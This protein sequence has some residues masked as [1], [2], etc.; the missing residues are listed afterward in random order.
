MEGL[1]LQKFYRSLQND[2]SANQLGNEEGASQEQLFTELAVGLLSEGGE[3]E[4]VRIAYDEKVS[5]T[6][7]QHKIN[8]YSLSENLETLD[9]FISIYN[10]TDSIAGLNKAPVETAQKR[11][12]NFF[13]TA[14]YKDYAKEIEESS[15]IFD[16][17]NTLGTSQDVREG[18]AR[19]NAFILTDGVFN[20][21][22]V[23][24]Q[25]ISGYPIYFRVI[26][27][28]YL[29]N[30]S[31]KSHI[32]IEIDFAAD[33]F[34]IPFI[35]A[36]SEN[37]QYNSYLAIIPG[38]ALANIYER[39]GARL[40][41]QNIRSFLQFTGKINKGIRNTILKEPHMF[42]AF[43]N[44]I[45][46]TADTLEVSADG[47][48][49]SKVHDLQIVNGG[50][51]TASIFHTWKKDKADVSNIHVQLKL[52]VVKEKEKFSEI[53]SRI[54]E[55]ANT[56]N[57]VSVSDLSS[58]QPFHIEIEKL[59]RT[60]W[61]APVEGRSQQTSWFYERARGQYKNARAKDGFTKVKQGAFDLKNPKNQLFTKEDLAKYCNAF[62]EQTDGKKII[63]GPHIV[64]R[65]NQKNYAHFVGLGFP[66]KL[67]NI[68]FEDVVSK[69]I[70]YKTAEKKYGV[71]PNAIGDMR[72]V[73]VPYTL[74][75]FN[76]LT[77][78]K[79]DLFKIWRAQSISNDLKDCLYNLMIEVEQFIK[80]N[81]TGSL[82]GEF[83]KKEECWNLLKN[84]GIKI[85]SASIKYDLG[86]GKLDPF[87]T[88]VSQ[89]E[90]ARIQNEQDLQY[91]VSISPELWKHI[92]NWGR[93]TDNLT[94]RQQDFAFNLS[95][96]VRNGGKGISESEKEGG[97]KILDFVVDKFPEVFE[98]F[99]EPES[100]KAKSTVPEITLQIIQAVVTWDR[101]AKRFKD[102]EYR[103][104]ADLASGNQPLVD[105]NLQKANWYY[106][107][108]KQYG[109]VN[110]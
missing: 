36:P 77:G 10:G 39:Y 12:I 26:D 7:I 62:S 34:K 63:T 53:V 90:T 67:D 83:A 103:F 51:T 87:R 86:N 66:K 6:G 15:E 65:G 96:R 30:I 81:A 4:N 8:A 56:Q 24:K 45:S 2:I 21:E 88:K 106:Q 89:D 75:Y 42:L 91:L 50:Q 61:A 71:K 95:S 23:L 69:M 28:N 72:Y 25:E 35:A 73:T 22:I 79:L 57:K 40:L 48:Y 70:L 97:L 20:S 49:I 76:Y 98:E 104:M 107:K 109:F 33:G 27:L 41:E 101:K 92:E 85:D 29:Y 58:N 52:N 93:A 55:Y 47:K 31:E 18:L 82:Y 110:E 59:S 60:I 17:A 37:L 78:N 1:E 43:N 44:G 105:R 46:A 100:V 3:T 108:A 38:D 13:K 94:L 74:S 80:D 16:L 14:V 5:R 102:H 9:I 84:S 99:I 64:V 68:Y 19:V 32:P 54:A 11:I